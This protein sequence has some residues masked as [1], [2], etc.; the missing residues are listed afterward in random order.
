VGYDYAGSIGPD[1]EN[2]AKERIEFRINKYYMLAVVERLKDH[3]G[4]SL[5][6]ACHFH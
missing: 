5:N 1:L 4:R 6:S 2:R 3:A